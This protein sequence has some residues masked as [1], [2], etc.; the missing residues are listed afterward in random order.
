MR[1]AQ[2]CKE[3]GAL[4]TLEL[5]TCGL[6][7]LCCKGGG[8]IYITKIPVIILLLVW[9]HVYCFHLVHPTVLSFRADAD[10]GLKYSSGGEGKVSNPCRI[11][12][13]FMNCCTC[14]LMGTVGWE[15]SEFFYLD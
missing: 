8:L 3:A 2:S 5:V 14:E 13:C 7:L 1:E 11:D 6:G 4:V 10:C 9:M 15:I 12:M